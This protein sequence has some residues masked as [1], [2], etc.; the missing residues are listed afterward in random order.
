MLNIFYYDA[1]ENAYIPDN[2]EGADVIV[3]WEVPVADLVEENPDRLTISWNEI[4]CRSSD[5]L[6]ICSLSS[7]SISLVFHDDHYEPGYW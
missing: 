1:E 7:K 5:D 3:S 6:G 4:F 2:D